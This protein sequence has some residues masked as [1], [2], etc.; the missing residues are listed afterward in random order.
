LFGFGSKVQ[1]EAE[2]ASTLAENPSTEAESTAQGGDH[3]SQAEHMEKTIEP[4]N[5]V[6]NPRSG[7]GK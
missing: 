6:S 2:K 4:N 5:I 7:S 3:S 1:H